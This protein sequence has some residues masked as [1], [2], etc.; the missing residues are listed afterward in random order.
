[1]AACTP[2]PSSPCSY[3]SSF[4]LDPWP[5]SASSVRLPIGHQEGYLATYLSYVRM[6][7]RPSPVFRG[8][9]AYTCAGTTCLCLLSPP[10]GLLASSLATT[11]AHQPPSPAVI[12]QY[13]GSG[14]GGLSAKANN[15][16]ASNIVK[17]GGQSRL[18]SWSSGTD[19]SGKTH[20]FAPLISPDRWLLPSRLPACL[21]LTHR[22]P[23]R[24]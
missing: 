2:R 23:P 16:S 18:P 11:P 13:P 17:C 6:L 1:M 7:D 24:R 8:E 15:Y 5:V 22:P 20:P 14:V 19:F 12:S 10:P 3:R 21:T 9:G 4:V